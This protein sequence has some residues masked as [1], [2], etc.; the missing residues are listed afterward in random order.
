MNDDRSLLN[1]LEP[2]AESR[3]QVRRKVAE[4]SHR[5][6]KQNS[7]SRRQANSADG[8]IER[9]KHFGRRQNVGVSERIEERGFPGVR[10]SLR[11]DHAQR[12]RWSR[13]AACGALAANRF[14]GFLD[15]A[16]AIAD[17]PA[18]GLEFLF[19]RAA[20]SDAAAQPG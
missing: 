8:G 17:S 7:A 12:K 20:R 6:G 15:F 14:N 13:L 4:K 18:V 1:F 9:G 16:D 11:G 19:S 10:V 2:G 3:D 5:V